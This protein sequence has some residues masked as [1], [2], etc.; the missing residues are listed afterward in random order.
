MRHDDRRWR[1]AASR[2]VGSVWAS[3][4]ESDLIEERFYAAYEATHS[5]A[6]DY[7]QRQPIYH[8]LVALRMRIRRRDTA[9]VCDALGIASVTFG[10]HLE[11]WG[12]VYP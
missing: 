2:D 7:R 8:L 6:T 10:L 4:P 11:R 9:R 12:D 5:I 3:N 1:L